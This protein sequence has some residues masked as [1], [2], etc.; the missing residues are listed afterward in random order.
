MSALPQKMVVISGW[1]AYPRL[2]VEG[3]HAAGVRQVDV[4][5]VRGSTDPVALDQ[6]CTD[7]CNAAPIMPGCALDGVDVKGDIFTA[8]HPE[9]RWQDA[10][11]E[12]VRMKLGS[13]EY[14]LKRI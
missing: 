2:I 9:T 7:L 10:I 1:G 3:A 6:A 4:L 14:T 11:A 5:A 12:G 13:A 8:M